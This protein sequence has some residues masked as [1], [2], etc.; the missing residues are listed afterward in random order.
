MGETLA[1]TRIEIET[2]RAQ[3]EAE[4]SE[5][6]SRVRHALDFKARFRENPALFVGLGAGA[7]FLIAGGPM[8]VARLVRRRLRPTTAE[9]AHDALPKPM[10]A[11]VDSLVGDVGPKADKAR[12]ALTQELQRWR[13]EPLKNKKA[14]KELA[15]AM[16]EGPPGPERTVWKAAEAGLTLLSAAMARKAIEAF[17]TGEKPSGPK[18]GAKTSPPSPQEAAAE[19]SGFSERSR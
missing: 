16:V 10:Q 12:L 3:M 1:E 9:Q 2:H 11:W 5:L 18:A 13:H 14:R 19:Y 4:A 7:V 6:E 17:I 15:K 8:R